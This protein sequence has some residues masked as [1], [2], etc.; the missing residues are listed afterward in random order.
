MR[1]GTPP[2]VGTV[3]TTEP[4]LS[5]ALLLMP[6]M[7]PAKFSTWSLLFRVTVPVSMG[8]GVFVSRSNR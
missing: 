6:S 1:V 5:P 8:V 3:K 2:V 4:S 7:S